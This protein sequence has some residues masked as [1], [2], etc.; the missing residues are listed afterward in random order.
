MGLKLGT[1]PRSKEKAL[2]CS[3]TVL[4]FK[5][6]NRARGILEM[7]RKAIGVQIALRQVLFRNNS[8]SQNKLFRKRCK[9]DF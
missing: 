8:L 7:E 3:F 2:I 5:I 6:L 4:T 1:I 9:K